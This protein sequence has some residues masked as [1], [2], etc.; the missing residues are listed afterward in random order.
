M[1]QHTQIDIYVKPSVIC[2]RTEIQETDFGCPALSEQKRIIHFSSG[3]TLTED[4]SEEEEEQSSIGE[5]AER[6]GMIV[7]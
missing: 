4:D 7:G 5:P 6:V 1:Y 3:D 2:Q